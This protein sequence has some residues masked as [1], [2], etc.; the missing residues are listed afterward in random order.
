M[1]YYKLTRS[2]ISWPIYRVVDA[3]PL[4]FSFSCSGG[5]KKHARSFEVIGLLKS[6]SKRS[7]ISFWVKVSSDFNV[8]VSTIHRSKSQN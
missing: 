7:W 4:A 2:P 8:I 5:K 3:P 6:L 1:A